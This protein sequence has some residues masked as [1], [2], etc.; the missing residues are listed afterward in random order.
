MNPFKNLST[1]VAFVAAGMLV[2]C[3][4]I[5]ALRVAVHEEPSRWEWLP[6]SV[7][8]S[9]R[10]AQLSPEDRESIRVQLDQ[11]SGTLGDLT[12]LAAATKA[13][14]E[15]A[16]ADLAVR[17]PGA[18]PD[19]P[20]VRDAVSVVR[21]A[22]A[23]DRLTDADELGFARLQLS[24]L[25]AD[26]ADARERLPRDAF[27]P[28]ELRAMDAAVRR[29]NEAIPVLDRYNAA[30]DTLG[31]FVRES[32][33]RAGDPALAAKIDAWLGRE[34]KVSPPAA[35]APAWQWAT[36]SAELYRRTSLIIGFDD[37]RY[38]IQRL[39][40]VHVSDPALAGVLS[41]PHHSGSSI[42]M[43]ALSVLFVLSVASRMPLPQPA[44]P[45]RPQQ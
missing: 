20:E 23:L 44:K 9:A 11:L 12:A 43:A 16:L 36:P 25:R 5:A 14:R 42:A 18:L 34:T 1:N 6:Q 27:G 2:V 26:V 32:I 37:A 3:G 29:V 13:R 10:A 24:E 41:D 39:E 35:P 15:A 40:P 30:L 4:G 45:A 38:P 31:S 21:D 28:R 8:T 22:A 17:A 7:A 19:A 33:T